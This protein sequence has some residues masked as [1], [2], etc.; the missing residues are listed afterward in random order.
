MQPYQ[1]EFSPYQ[2]GYGND[3]GY[4]EFQSLPED[5]AHPVMF[6]R[7]RRHIDFFFPIFLPWY[8][9]PYPYF[10]TYPYPYGWFW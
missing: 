1:P 5:Q 3:Q 9:Y 10:Y 8:P 2:Q 7:G 6:R 4:Q